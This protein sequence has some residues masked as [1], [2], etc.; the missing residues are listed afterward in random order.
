MVQYWGKGYLVSAA[1]A[2]AGAEVLPD[3]QMRGRA[4][5]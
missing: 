5:I 1:G 2:I 3:E 4:V